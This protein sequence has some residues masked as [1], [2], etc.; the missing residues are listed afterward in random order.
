MEASRPFASL[1]AGLLARKGQARPA[2]R[3]FRESGDNDLGWNDM[4]HDR[5][6]VHPVQ[7]VH[8]Q[9]EQIAEF[10]RQPVEPPKAAKPTRKTPVAKEKP[11]AAEVVEPKPVVVAKPSVDLKS[12]TIAKP[13][14]SLVSAHKAAFTLRLD[15]ERHLRLR[16]ACAVANRS[17]QQLV[18]E[19][20]DA[21]LNAMPQVDELARQVGHAEPIKRR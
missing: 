1:S 4:G 16:L 9:Q 2:M 13:M 15:A 3:P 5:P 14:A 7:P 19:A 20:V 8:E 17:A 18:I 12:A 10:V 21:M 11:T 6:R